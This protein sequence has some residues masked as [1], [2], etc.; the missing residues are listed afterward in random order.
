LRAIKRAIVGA[1]K[2]LRT[3]MGNK[4]Y[5]K[6]RYLCEELVRRVEEGKAGQEKYIRLIL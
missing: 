5:A 3:G 2:E 4:G 1:A 6:V